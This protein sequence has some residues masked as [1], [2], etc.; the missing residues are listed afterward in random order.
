MPRR[1]VES[2]RRPRPAF[3]RSKN[4]PGGGVG[5]DQHLKPEAGVVRRAQSS[6]SRCQSVPRA[7]TKVVDPEQRREINLS[8]AE[9][10]PE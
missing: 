4:E 7:E 1:G 5:L 6:Q 8:A 9:I 3:L 2:C 10:C